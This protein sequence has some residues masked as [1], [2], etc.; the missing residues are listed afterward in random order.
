MFKNFK[1]QISSA[2]GGLKSHGGFTLLE[3]MV[4]RALLSGLIITIIISLNYHL[5]IVDMDKDATIATLL[6]REKMEEIKIQGIPDRHEGDFAPLFQGQRAK[7][8]LWKHMMS[9][10]KKLEMRNRLLSLQ[11]FSSV[12]SKKGFSLLELLIAV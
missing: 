8:F 4:A 10:S 1:F 9:K 7:R 5:S 12:F 11:A 2:L 3:I 6:A